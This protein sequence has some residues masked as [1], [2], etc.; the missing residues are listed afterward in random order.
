MGYFNQTDLEN[1]L[2][3]KIVKQ[4]YDDD[5]DTKTDAGPI[6]ACIA[7]GSAQCDSFLRAAYGNSTHQAITLPLT[8]VPAEVKFAALDFG[9]AYTLR[10]RPDLVQAMNEQPWTVYHQAAVDQMKR[11]C[12]SIQR[13]PVD[14][15]G[16]PATVGGSNYALDPEDDDAPVRR[17]DDM[18]DFS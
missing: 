10:R 8:T 15:V 7:Y 16:T 2:G 12:E 9:I 4:I 1:A 13:F 14:T 5:H 6:A 17:F 11:Y 3:K 18:G